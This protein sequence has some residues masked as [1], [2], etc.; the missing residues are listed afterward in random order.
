MA[1]GG[2]VTS[3]VSSL[4]LVAPVIPQVPYNSY[5]II[6]SP[7][8]QTPQ[9]P[10]LYYHS[11][12]TTAMSSFSLDTSPTTSNT[13]KQPLTMQ[14]APNTQFEAH[15]T[16]LDDLPAETRE[17]VQQLAGANTLRGLKAKCKEL[18]I[19][20]SVS[21]IELAHRIALCHQNPHLHSSQQKTQTTDISRDISENS[22]KDILLTFL[23]NLGKSK[24]L[25]V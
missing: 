8:A 1:T 13:T 16:N 20:Y 9:A 4:Q 21:K 11:F 2:S 22:K 19:S 23:H 15:L 25:R 5:S 10:L 7:T 6:P 3:P 24:K 17:L 18:G 14:T 12:G